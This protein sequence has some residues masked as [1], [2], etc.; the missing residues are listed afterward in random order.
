MNGGFYAV[1][2]G[3]LIGCDTICPLSSEQVPAMYRSAS[4]H[5]SFW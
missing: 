1:S 5:G 2:S 3:N 4:S